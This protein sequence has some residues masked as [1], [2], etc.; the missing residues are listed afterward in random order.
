MLVAKLW[1]WTGLLF[2]CRL[3]ATGLNLIVC[4][5][6]IQAIVSY[7]KKYRKKIKTVKSVSRICWLQL[8][9][10]GLFMTT[11]MFSFW[12]CRRCCF[13]SY[14]DVWC[15][16]HNT[17]INTKKDKKNKT[18]KHQTKKKKHRQIKQED[19]DDP[20]LS[21]LESALTVLQHMHCSL[22]SYIHVQWW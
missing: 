12:L 5:R 15:H 22:Y 8:V 2:A 7:N 6:G 11:T 10:S 19:H 16:Q 3:T 20:V 9:S 13:N 18:T 21:W 14:W 4:F 17:S 1:L